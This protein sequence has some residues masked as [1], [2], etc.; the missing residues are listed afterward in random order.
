MRFKICPLLFLDRNW[1]MTCS[2]R[3]SR[4]LVVSYLGS[5]AA[6]G[7]NT[8]LQLFQQRFD[9]SGVTCIYVSMLQCR[10]VDQPD[11]ARHGFKSA[12]QYQIR[13]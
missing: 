1:L 4:V 2:P 3:S 7:K 10:S 12:K 8:Q 11:Q 9:E 5:P 6:S 13:Y